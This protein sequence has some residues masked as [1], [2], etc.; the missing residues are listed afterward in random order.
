MINLLLLG[1][2]HCMTRRMF[3][4]TCE[5]HW[6]GHLCETKIN[7]C[8]SITCL[9]GGVCRPSIGNWTCECPSKDYFGRH[10]ELT[11]SRIVTYRL[12]AKSFAYI[13]IVA[14]SLVAMFIVMMDILKYCFGVDLTDEDRKK[15]T[16]TKDL[17][18]RPLRAR[19]KQSLV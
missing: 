15:K 12:V 5:E 8:R 4:C 11:T 1:I 3:N 10:C 17:L 19:K 9:N 16:I 13:A 6:Q 2:C 14:M 7:Y 18:R